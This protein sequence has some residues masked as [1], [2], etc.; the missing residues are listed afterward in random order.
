MILLDNGNIINGDRANHIDIGRFRITKKGLRITSQS[1]DFGFCRRIV[2]LSA[3]ELLG[4]M[5]DI[6]IE[7]IE[8]MAPTFFQQSI[9]GV[10]ILSATN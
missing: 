2:E 5:G 6:F 4:F 8:V 10:H 9:G 7:V 3:A 1:P